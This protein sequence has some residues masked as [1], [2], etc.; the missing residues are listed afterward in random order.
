MKLFVCCHLN[1]LAIRGLSRFITGGLKILF[2]LAYYAAFGMFFRLVN[3]GVEN[4][5]SNVVLL[6]QYCNVSTPTSNGFVTFLQINIFLLSRITKRSGTW[7]ST[8]QPKQEYSRMKL[9]NYGTQSKKLKNLKW[10]A[11]QR[12]GILNLNLCTGRPCFL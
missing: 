5:L 6:W 4:S 7:L 8:S 12:Q 11:N 3:V 2:P 1:V 9:C 10:P